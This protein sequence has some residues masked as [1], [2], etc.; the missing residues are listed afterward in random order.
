MYI[1][2]L[3]RSRRVTLRERYR[4]ELY[5]RMCPDIDSTNHGLP[6]PSETL[7]LPATASPASWATALRTPSRVAWQ[8][9]RILNGPAVSPSF[10]ILARLVLRSRAPSPSTSITSECCDLAFSLFTLSRR[11]AQS[12]YTRSLSGQYR[13][14]WR[15]VRELSYG[16]GGR[17][18]SPSPSPIWLRIFASIILHCA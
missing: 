15:C 17:Y 12:P 16:Y 18:T 1:F 14:G 9:L 5:P 8:S 6:Y 13:A 10:R 4:G 11:V 7:F 3:P 2:V